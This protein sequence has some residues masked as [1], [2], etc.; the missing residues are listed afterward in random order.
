MTTTAMDIMVRIIREGDDVAIVTR[1]AHETALPYGRV[2][3]VPIS[4]LRRYRHG[5]EV[6][7]GTTLVDVGSDDTPAYWTP[8]M[9]AA[10]APRNTRPQG[11]R[12]AAADRDRDREGI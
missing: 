7:S 11:G 4:A 10:H 2:Y 9:V 12:S 3:A 6:V 1:A 5:A 8:D